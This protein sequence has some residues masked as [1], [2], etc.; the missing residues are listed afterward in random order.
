M[1]TEKTV[2]AYLRNKI[3]KLGGICY[4][5]VSPG[6]VAVPD[7]ICVLPGLIAFVECKGPGGKVNKKQHRELQRLADLKMNVFVVTTKA[8][9]DAL[10]ER[11]KGTDANLH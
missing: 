2:E 11:L 8:E 7:R 5:F 3:E 6:R 1:E 4:K 9:V 10:I